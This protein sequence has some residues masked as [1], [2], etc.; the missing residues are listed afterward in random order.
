MGSGRPAIPCSRMQF[1]QCRSRAY[2]SGV[3]GSD[4]TCLT[5][6]RFLQAVSAVRNA[7]EDELIPGALRANAPPLGVG[8]GKL[9]TPCERMQ[10]AKLSPCCWASDWLALELELP[11]RSEL[12]GELEPQAA[13]ATAASA[14]TAAAQAFRSRAFTSPQRSRGSLKSS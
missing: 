10:R 11:E 1:A 6:S 8:S 5:G 12:G 4:W 13:I 7:G 14:A 3:G 2:A 9:G